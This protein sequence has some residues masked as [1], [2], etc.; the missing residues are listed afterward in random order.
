M[1]FEIVCKEMQS[2][3]HKVS[4]LWHIVSSEGISTN[5]EKV[6]AVKTWPVPKNVKQ[7]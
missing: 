5:P 4:F 1:G 7:G 6:E 2:V 3:Q